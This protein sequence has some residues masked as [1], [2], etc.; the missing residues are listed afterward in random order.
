[1]GVDPAVEES[2]YNYFDLV[3]LARN[4]EV[5]KATAA[6]WIVFEQEQS[7]VEVGRM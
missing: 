6:E 5:G 1:M 3:E 7:V 4:M 2:L